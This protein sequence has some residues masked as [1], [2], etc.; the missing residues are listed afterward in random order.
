[1]AR[2]RT[3]AVWLWLILPLAV[4]LGA[5]L[6]DKPSD[7][8]VQQRLRT[9]LP[10]SELVLLAYV[11]ALRDEGRTREAL[12]SAKD[13]ATLH[14][15]SQGAHRALLLMYG[16]RGQRNEA[17]Q[18]FDELGRLEAVVASDLV[19]AAVLVQTDDADLA[20]T[21]Y[22]HALELDAN[23][24]EAHA[25]LATIL[26][27]IRRWDAARKHLAQALNTSPG[28]VPVLLNLGI[29][30]RRAG[31]P[32]IAIEQFENVL[33]LEPSNRLARQL[34]TETQQHVNRGRAGTSRR[35]ASPAPTTTQ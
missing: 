13:F 20:A 5:Q 33:R 18:E 25:N 10:E 29:L 8:E 27:G 3:F 6:G 7:I 22:E 30:E 15:D 35:R 34:L 28:S 21:Y 14:P 1:M 19:A 12:E 17:L 31:R 9:S 26:I 11:D 4:L 16:E 24:F 32:Q 23:N 2:V